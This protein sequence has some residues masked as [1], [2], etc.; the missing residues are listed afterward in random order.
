[1]AEA[2]RWLVI[3]GIIL[4]VVGAAFWGLGRIGFRGLPGDIRYETDNVRVYFPV[5]TCLV[6]SVLLSLGMWLWQWL[7]RR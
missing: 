4:V 5:V 2:G 7:S 3:M 1:M 6:L